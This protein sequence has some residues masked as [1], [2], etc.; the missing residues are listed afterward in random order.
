M[1]EENELMVIEQKPGEVIVR[2]Q[3]AAAQLQK[4]VGSREKKLLLGGKQYLFFEDW[5]TIGKFYGVTPKIVETSEIREGDKLVGF[6]AKAVAIYDRGEV[7]GA[8]AECAYDEPNWSGKPR[9][10]LRSMAQTR[11]C[12]KALR[13]CLGWVA[14]LAGYEATP[15]E[16]M[17][18]EKQSSSATETVAT[19]AQL[20][21]IYATAKEQEYDSALAT[22]IMIRL[23]GTGHSK[24]LTKKQASE[25][26]QILSE[27]KF[28]DENPQDTDEP[29]APEDLPF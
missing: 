21:K 19:I 28:K 14:V 25:F 20:K 10:Q 16:E 29:L 6:L 27:G 26:I 7:S 3:E 22:S 24:S 18:G 12:A 11:A 2:G 15:A 9:Y 1:K 5:Q 23:Y 8:E 17:A 4:I 13:N